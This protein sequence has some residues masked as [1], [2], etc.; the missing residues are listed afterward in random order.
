MT[1]WPLCVRYSGTHCTKGMSVGTTAG[2]LVLVLFAWVQGVGNTSPQ[3]QPAP[4]FSFQAY[5]LGVAATQVLFALCFVWVLRQPTAP[6]QL[7]IPSSPT[8]GR[9]TRTPSKAALMVDKASSLQ[10]G[11]AAG[12]ASDGGSMKQPLLAKAGEGD[13]AAVGGGEDISKVEQRCILA[14][15]C[16][17]YGLTYSLPSVAPYMIDSYGANVT[18]PGPKIYML[19]TIGTQAGDVAGRASTLVPWV[20]GSA[21]LWLMTGLVVAISGLLVCAGVWSKHMPSILPGWFGLFYPTMF[22]LYYFIRGYV[23][24]ILYVRVK[25]AMPKKQAEA[26]SS[27]MGLCGQIGAAAGCASFYIVINWLKWF[28][29]GL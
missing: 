23:V 13:A 27:N 5:M 12:D 16:V 2:G 24:T 11:Q 19:I 20:P 14:A 22:F 8:Q 3:H 7:P 9:V 29:T 6:E 4:L 21:L 1:Y 10:G 28:P 18:L 15:I 25:V 26:F 17:I